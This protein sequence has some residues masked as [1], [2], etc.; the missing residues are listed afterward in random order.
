MDKKQYLVPIIRSFQV[1]TE[2]SILASVVHAEG[3]HPGADLVEDPNEVF[4]F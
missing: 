2:T 1:L 4:T 3:N